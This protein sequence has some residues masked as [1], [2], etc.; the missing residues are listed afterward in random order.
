MSAA[1]PIETAIQHGQDAESLIARVLAGEQ[2]AFAGL[3]RLYNRNLFRAVR[4]IL[5]DDQEAEDALQE[6]WILVYRKLSGFRGES[7]LATWLTRIAVNAALARR[8][9]RTRQAQVI[10]LWDDG[11]ARQQEDAMATP[12]PRQSPEKDAMRG[13]M[14]RVLEHAID[15]LPEQFRTVFILRALEEMPS[16]DVA[17]VL[18]I[19]EST[20]RT[21]Y[22]RARAML[23][24]LLAREVDVA[25]GEAFSFAGE[26]CAR[27]TASVMQMLQQENG[28][29][30]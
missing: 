29:S 11:A 7:G 6:A 13:E 8:R 16:E 15:S 17:A 1:P 30:R 10:A 21:R 14:R 12:D 19:P 9:Q 25:E 5:R 3:M 23:R 27:I 22:F 2:A 4:S 20:A 24:E 28:I 26:R 18:D